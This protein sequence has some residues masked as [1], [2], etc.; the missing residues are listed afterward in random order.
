ML[1][2]ADMLAISI[3]A[4]GGPEVLMPVRLPLPDRAPGDVLIRVAAAGVNAPDLSQRRGRY[5]P[6]PGASPLPGLEVSGTIAALG[7]EA[8][9]W[10]VGD[11]VVALTNGGGYAEYVA[12]PAGQVLPLPAGW[13][14]PAG[15]A[16]PETFF[17]VAQTLVMRAGLAPG[18]SVLIHGAAGGIGGAAIQIAKLLGA[19]PIAVVSD[20]AKAEYVKT[21]GV[22]PGDVIMHTTEDVVARTRD[23]TDGRGADRILHMAGGPTLERDIDAAARGG[24]IVLVASLS[25]EA[26]SIAAGK[27]VAKWLTLSGSTLRPQSSAVKAAIAQCLSHDI[28]P[29]LA[30]GRIVPPRLVTLPMEQAAAAHVEMEKR[31]NYGKLVLLTEYGR[32]ASG[33]SI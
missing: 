24:H 13:S 15:A 29:A 1:L 5:A 30:D 9:G 27:L 7:P 4:P 10:N 3:V 25:G 12:V 26:S 17:T 2:P 22:A 28:W 21:L 20:A 18:L 8:V 6:P 16:L 19:R 33:I 32:A 31:E 23:L 14:L 11:A